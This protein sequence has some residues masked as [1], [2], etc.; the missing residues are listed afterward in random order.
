MLLHFI[1]GIVLLHRTKLLS[2]IFASDCRSS[3]YANSPYTLKDLQEILANT[4]SLKG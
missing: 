3:P 2:L 1:I 4:N